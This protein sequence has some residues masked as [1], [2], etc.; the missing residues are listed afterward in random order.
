[1]E[2]IGATMITVYITQLWCLYF[3]KVC[4]IHQTFV[5]FLLSKELSYN[6]LE[7]KYDTDRYMCM[8]KS[9]NITPYIYINKPQLGNVNTYIYS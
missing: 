4:I 5:G 2:S 8:C 9:M 3:V 6:T 1:M 7:Y